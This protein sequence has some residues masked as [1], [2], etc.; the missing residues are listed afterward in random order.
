MD[1]CILCN[2][3]KEDK[4]SSNFK[5]AISGIRVMMD[6]SHLLVTRHQKRTTKSLSGTAIAH[7]AKLV[8]I[9]KAVCL[10]TSEE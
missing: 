7:F 8:P 4:S 6:G 1:T 3:I 2:L 9:F 10:N 5:V